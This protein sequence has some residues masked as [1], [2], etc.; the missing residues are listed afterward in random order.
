MDTENLLNKL[1]IPYRR[2]DHPPV[3]TVD[4]LNDHLEGH[5][6]IKNLFLKDDTKQ[7]YLI[8]MSGMKRLDL[9]HVAS[10]IN[11]KKLRFASPENM[12]EILGVTPGSVSLFGLINDTQNKVKAFIESDLLKQDEISFHPNDNTATIF[13]DP[14]YINVIANELGCQIIPI[15]I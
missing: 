14:K 7:Y 1:G 10:V 13:F 2:V 8:M 15:A 12:M 9:K 11:S 4:D 3:F 6:P 5:Y